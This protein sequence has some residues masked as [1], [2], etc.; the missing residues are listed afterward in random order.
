MKHEIKSISKAE[1]SRSIQG[2]LTCNHCKCT[3]AGTA[4]QAEHVVYAGKNVYCSNACRYAFLK[5]KFSTPVPNRGACGGC[6]EKFY[7]RRDAK[8]CGMKCYTGS[9]QFSNMLADSRAKSMT[10]ESIAKR[11]KM[12]RRGEV[13]PCLEC[14]ADVYIKKSDLNKKFCNKG[15]YRT[16]MAKRFDRQIASPDQMTLPQGYDA[17]LDRDE[18][19]CLIIGCDWTGKH[20][21]IHMNSAHGIQAN[22]FKRAAGFNKGTGVVSKDVAQAL[23]DRAL[24]G[25]AMDCAAWGTSEAIKAMINRIIYNSTESAEHRAKARALVINCPT[26]TCNGCGCVFSQSTPFGKTLYCTK[27]CRDNAYSKINKAKRAGLL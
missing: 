12:L 2:S 8:F 23:R 21:S 6:G 20:L 14:G 5:E 26:R 18:L 4:K 10:P 22:D 15:C 25:V 24:Q 27:E 7:S 11:A 17:F 3:F 9:T 16:Y 1:L 19:N 13:N